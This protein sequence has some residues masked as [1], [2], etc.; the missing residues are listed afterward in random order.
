MDIIAAAAFAAAVLLTATWRLHAHDKF[1]YG[2]TV[3][4]LL[5]AMA[6]TFSAS[7][8]WTGLYRATAHGVGLVILGVTLSACGID[9]VLQVLMKHSKFK[10]ERTT[11][12]ALGLGVSGVLFIMNFT[13]I[14]HSVQQDLNS[15]SVTSV[16]DHVNGTGG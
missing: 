3:I 13:G 10:K 2:A 11:W 8:W 4:A 5:G 12:I 9:F 7:Y 14:Y 16:V 6:L 15:H 1:K